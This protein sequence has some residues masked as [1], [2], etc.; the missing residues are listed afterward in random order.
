MLRDGRGSRCRTLFK[1]PR[2][3]EAVEDTMMLLT[4]DLATGARWMDVPRC[5][6]VARAF[7]RA[8][9][10]LAGLS[11]GLAVAAAC[12]RSVAV[13]ALAFMKAD[14]ASTFYPGALPCRGAIPRLKSRPSRSRFH[15]ASHPGPSLWTAAHGCS[16][17]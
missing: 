5:R 7:A 2:A 4:G 12:R 6:P 14:P 11:E 9:G 3:R 8:D 15:C 16:R 10:R 17:G 13:A 1:V